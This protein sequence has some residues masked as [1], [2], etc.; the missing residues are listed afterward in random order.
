GCEHFQPGT[1]MPSVNGVPSP[2]FWRSAREGKVLRK[3]SFALCL[4]LDLALVGLAFA[5]EAQQATKVYR[6]GWL[7]MGAITPH[8]TMWNAFL[9]AMRELNY[10]ERRNLVVRRGATGDGRPDHLPEFVAGFL[11]D[12]VDVIVTTSTQETRAA[13]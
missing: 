5:A 3:T 1:S 8:S 12:G 6:V 9:D 11:R 7:S 2:R 4:V 10:E 13:Q